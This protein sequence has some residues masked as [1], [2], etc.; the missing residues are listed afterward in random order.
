MTGGIKHEQEEFKTPKV[1]TIVDALKHI[2]ALS[3][4]ANGEATSTRTLSRIHFHC[5]HFHIVA[6]R[7]Y[8]V[9][10]ISILLSYDRTSY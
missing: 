9:L 2:F 3:K 10:M 4:T 1:I 5:L 6:Q 7:R 8:V